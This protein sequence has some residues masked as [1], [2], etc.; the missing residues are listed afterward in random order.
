MYF[1]PGSREN[2]LIYIISKVLMEHILFFFSIHNV[3]LGNFT[4]DQYGLRQYS[5][6]DELVLLAWIYILSSRFT[7]PTSCLALSVW[8]S[9]HQPQ[10]NMTKTKQLSYLLQSMH[11]SPQAKYRTCTR[12]FPSNSTSNS[13]VRSISTISKIIHKNQYFITIHLPMPLI[14]GHTFSC[15]DYN[16]SP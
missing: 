12:F 11:K 7:Y 9:S 3:S 2:S 5:C 6:A 1:T 10:L 4:T 8:R 14:Q 15:L 16:S 13:S